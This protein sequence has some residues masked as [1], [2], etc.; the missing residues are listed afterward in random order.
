M[1]PRVRP[2]LPFLMVLGDQLRKARAAQ[3]GHPSV[4]GDGVE[5]DMA[6]WASHQ[7]PA[8][9]RDLDGPFWIPSRART[10]TTDRPPLAEMGEP[11]SFN[12]A[13]PAA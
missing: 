8:V 3:D 13:R 12:P 6:N 11:R 2:A 1:I 7:G 5:R 4:T 9:E 10:D